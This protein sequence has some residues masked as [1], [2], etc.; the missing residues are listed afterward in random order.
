MLLSVGL[1]QRS[2]PRRPALSRAEIFMRLLLRLVGCELLKS[3]VQQR[4]EG[5]N[6]KFRQEGLKEVSYQPP[7]NVKIHEIQPLT[8]KKRVRVLFGGREGGMKVS[9][10]LIWR[11]GVLRIEWNHE[12]V[13]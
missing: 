3:V 13:P 12:G 10:M 2:L 9:M 5:A 6:R 1:T 8:V 4:N 11:V 7:N